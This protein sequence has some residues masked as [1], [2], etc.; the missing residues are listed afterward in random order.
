MYKSFG[1]WIVR[2]YEKLI[3]TGEI[4]DVLEYPTIASTIGVSVLFD[5]P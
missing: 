2:A 4:H 3:V 1:V 5:R